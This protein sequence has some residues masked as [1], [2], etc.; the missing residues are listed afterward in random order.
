MSN[1]EIHC[2][3]PG[4]GVP[5]LQVRCGVRLE[6]GDVERLGAELKLCVQGFSGRAFSLLLDTRKVR[7]TT[8]EALQLLKRLQKW[9]LNR[10]MI[11]LAHVV[12]FP[13][14]AGKLQESYRDRGLTRMV[15]AFTEIHPAHRFLD[16]GGLA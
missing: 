13:A 10:G 12:R 1:Y 11:R 15:D 7:E 6:T 9:A 8:R 3:I 14:M 4:G 2:T 16:E 5:I